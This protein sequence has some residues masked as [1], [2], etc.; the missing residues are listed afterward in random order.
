M[1]GVIDAA[2]AVIRDMGTF[3]QAGIDGEYLSA[4]K[5]GDNFSTIK[6]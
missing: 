2:C 4:V 6:K 3:E 5:G 1:F